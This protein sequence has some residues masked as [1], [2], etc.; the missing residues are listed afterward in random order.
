M[1]IFLFEESK[2]K[3]QAYSKSLITMIKYADWSFIND[4]VVRK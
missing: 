2:A 3:I 1:Y 4:F